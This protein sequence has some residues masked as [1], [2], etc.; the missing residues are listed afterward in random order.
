MQA[1][2]ASNTPYQT[3]PRI[4]YTCS[5]SL[6]RPHFHERFTDLIAVQS[7]SGSGC[8]TGAAIHKRLQRVDSF[9]QSLSRSFPAPPRRAL[10]SVERRPPPTT[11]SKF[12]VITPHFFS[13]S[14]LF[15]RTAI[16]SPGEMS[17]FSS[18]A[19]FVLSAAHCA[20]TLPTTNPPLRHSSLFSL[21]LRF[22]SFPRHHTSHHA[23]RKRCAP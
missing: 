11:F 22:P 19:G 6:L 9:R 1:T 8:S 2:G 4:P 21:H 12:S 15:H 16:R 20:R 17:R 3:A 10:H 14:L 18:V 23:Y 7:Y 13:L 5:R